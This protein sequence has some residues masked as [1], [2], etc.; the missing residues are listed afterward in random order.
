MPFTFTHPAI[1]LPFTYLNRKWF[2]LTGLVIGSLTPDFEYFLRMKVKS[3]YS[4][5][6]WG[7]LWFDLPLG[8]ILAFI[9][10]NLVRD[11][12]FKNSPTLFKSRLS[13]FRQ[14]DWNYFFKKNWL[15]V[16][17][18]LLIG[19]T[20][21]LFW[22][23]FT[24][25]SG[26]FV[27]KNSLLR[28]NINLLGNEIPVYK[29]LQHGSSL[30]GGLIIAIAFNKLPVDKNITNKIKLNY[31]MSI[32]VLTFLIIS[33]RIISGLKI[34]QY[35]NIIVTAISAVIVSLILYSIGLVILKKIKTS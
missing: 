17:I 15:I 23:S 12:L 24:H 27:V 18:S 20:S 21:H 13:K 19:I 22:D 30:I 5:T 4:H 16:L 9:F 1:I 10:H 34:N 28:Y 8:L 11:N 35:G 25:S 31:W 26:Y 2:S 3:N 14:F 29:I 32:A 6:L 33:I 7:M